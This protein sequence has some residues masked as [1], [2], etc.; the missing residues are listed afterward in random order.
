M[1]GLSF[2]AGGLSLVT[3]W[4]AGSCVGAGIG[5]SIERQPM[6]PYM[7]T[8]AILLTAGAGFVAVGAWFT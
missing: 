6:R 2:L 8:A 4:A 3:L 1:S 5:A 7:E